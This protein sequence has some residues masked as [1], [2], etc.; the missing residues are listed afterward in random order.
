MQEY[1]LVYTLM[2]VISMHSTLLSL[3]H[4]ILTAL[5][6]IV[7]MSPW[8]TVGFRPQLFFK[9]CLRPKDGRVPKLSTYKAGPGIY[10][11]IPVYPST[12]VFNHYFTPDDLLCELVFFNTFEELNLPITGPMRTRGLSSCMNHPHPNPVS[13]CGSCGEH[14]GQSPPYAVVS[15]WKRNSDD[16]SPVQQAQ[17][18]RFPVGLC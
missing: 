8:K 13:V 11:Y 12:Y 1:T 14:G 6:R 2:Y 16:P 17:G 3:F 5:R 4:L 10:K 9:C 18:I 7:M 15:G